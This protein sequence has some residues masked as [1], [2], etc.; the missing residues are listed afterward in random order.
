MD[1]LGNPQLILP[2]KLGKSCLLRPNRNSYGQIL[3]WWALTAGAKF[4][5][6]SDAAAVRRWETVCYTDGRAVLCG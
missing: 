4:M 1:K 5:A 6:A 3:G 2:G